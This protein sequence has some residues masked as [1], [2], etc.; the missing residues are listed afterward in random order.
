MVLPLWPRPRMSSNPG[1]VIGGN[2]LD[3]RQPRIKDLRPHPSELH[4]DR[5]FLATTEGVGDLADPEAGMGDAIP[6]APAAPGGGA[7]H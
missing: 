4:R 1:S 6:D 2:R 7:P 5:Y 3:R